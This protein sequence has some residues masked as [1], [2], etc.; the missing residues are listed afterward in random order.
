MRKTLRERT[1]QNVKIWSAFGIDGA[2]G[3]GC[4][5]FLMIGGGGSTAK[6]AA[7]EVIGVGIGR[8]GAG[9]TGAGAG[10]IA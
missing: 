5:A 3:A 9:R 7:A 6:R 2:L 10:R 8:V 4:S 1:L